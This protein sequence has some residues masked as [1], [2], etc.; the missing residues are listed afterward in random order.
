MI[1]ET[2]PIYVVEP[3]ADDAYLSLGGAIVDL[4]KAGRHVIIV[5]VFSGTR[6]RAADA[7]RYA[8]AVGAGYLG[9]GLVEAH[10][11][12]TVEIETPGLDVVRADLPRDGTMI[13]PLGIRHPEHRA[14]ARLAE[15]GDYAYL[16]TP[17]QLRR[18]NAAEVASLLDGR[19]IVHY[20]RP[21]WRRKYRHHALF[22]DQSMFFYRCPPES[23]APAVEM[24]VEAR[25]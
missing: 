18:R 8:A 4:V 2:G 19:T 10:Y 5:T 7:E 25:P 23:L 20:A 14:V 16:D 1:P 3:H 15:P 12:I 17:Y 13:F 21:D 6:K 11:S 22:K 24:I 9:L